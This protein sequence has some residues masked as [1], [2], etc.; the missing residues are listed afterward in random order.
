MRD[1]NPWASIGL[2]GHRTNEGSIRKD[3]NKYKRCL[4]LPRVDRSPKCVVITTTT[5]EGT[6]PVTYSFKAID[7]STLFFT[8]YAKTRS[9]Q[10]LPGIM[11][12]SRIVVGDSNKAYSEYPGD[13][14]KMFLEATSVESKVWAQPGVPILPQGRGRESELVG[15]IWHAEVWYCTKLRHII[16]VIIDSNRAYNVCR[17]CCRAPDAFDLVVGIDVD[18]MSSWSD[19]SAMT[20]K[21]M[22][23]SKCGAFGTRLLFD[24]QP[25]QV[26]RSHPSIP[27]RC[28]SRY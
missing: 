7:P 23:G 3:Q 26:L 19:H 24:L 15:R 9:H 4:S 16:C 5:G 11:V 1:R 17:S 2:E 21:P 14:F 25:E 20:K 13:F 8:I 6:V 12:G 10:G 28:G 27:G 22:K 18:S